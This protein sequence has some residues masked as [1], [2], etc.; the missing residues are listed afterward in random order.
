MVDES[1]RGGR[2]TPLKQNV[3]RALDHDG[4][5]CVQNVIVVYRTGES[6]PMSGRRDIWYHNLIDNASED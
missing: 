2:H 3:D 5:E 1:V 4:T 6:I